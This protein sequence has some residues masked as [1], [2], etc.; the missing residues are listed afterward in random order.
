MIWFRHVQKRDAG[1]V[2]R[3]MLKMEQPG[4]RRR[5][6]PRLRLFMDAVS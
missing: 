3:K 2:E 5:G 4:E 1:Y 6:R